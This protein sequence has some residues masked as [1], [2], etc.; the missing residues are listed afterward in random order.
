MSKSGKEHILLLGMVFSQEMV[1]KRGQEFRDRVRCVALE[2][3]GFFVH[4]LDEKHDD[5]PL[6]HGKHC[7]SNFNHH[8]NF[9]RHVKS[10]W[11]GDIKFS[12]VILD[13]FFSPIGWARDR[14]LPSFFSQTIPSMALELLSLGGK[15]WLPNLQNVADS[16][17]SNLPCFNEY[18]IIHEVAEPMKNPLYVATENA[19]EELL[20]CPDRMTNDT[21]L[22]P[23]LKRSSSPFYAL[24]LKKNKQDLLLPSVIIEEDYCDGKDDSGAE[25]TLHMWESINASPKMAG[26]LVRV[27]SGG[28]GS[29]QSGPFTAAMKDIQRAIAG[30]SRILIVEEIDT[31]TLC[32]LKWQPKQFCDWSLHSHAHMWLAHVHQSL[33]LHNLVWDMRD[34]L[35]EF[36]RLKYHTGFP[37]GD[38]LRCPV[39]TQDKIEYIKCLGDLAVNTLTVPLTKDGTYPDACLAEVQR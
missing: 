1:P 22:G 26:F 35:T 4:T 13:Y 32:G 11:G 16:I 20:R 6:V 38:Q 33:R 14:W 5:L 25:E 39:F 7:N 15:V 18:F 17:E 28:M 3:L 8:R 31:K 12:H 36:K 24:V 37:T 10:K 21:Q 34:A 29:T 19:T 23:L 27:F 30:T 2:D 9:I